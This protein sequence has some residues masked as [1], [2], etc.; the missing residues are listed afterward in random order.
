M[1]VHFC[2]TRDLASCGIV[3]A[4]LSLDA[5]DIDVFVAIRV[6]IGRSLLCACNKAGEG[7]LLRYSL[8]LV[9]VVKMCIS[10][11]SRFLAKELTVA[12]ELKA[13]LFS[14]NSLYFGT[15]GSD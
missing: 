3:G 11:S 8:K 9:S 6:A 14:Y 4:E 15:C 5:H 10:S 12:S 2:A 13:L 1:R 7:H